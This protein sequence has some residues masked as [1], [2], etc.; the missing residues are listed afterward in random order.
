VSQAARNQPA[1]DRLARELQPAVLAV[2]RER[3]GNA[4]RRAIARAVRRLPLVALVVAC[5]TVVLSLRIAVPFLVP[6]LAALVAVTAYVL[7]VWTRSFQVPVSDADAALACD[8]AHQSRDRLSAAL[9]LSADPAL[10]ARPVHEAMAAAAIE[11][12]LAFLQRTD[13]GRVAASTERPAADWRSAAAAL[14]ALALFTWWLPL[15]GG[16]SG[17][18]QGTQSAAGG[19]AAQGEAGRR[20]VAAAAA[21]RTEAPPAS[22]KEVKS[23]PKAA[24]NERRGSPPPNQP[25]P[26]PAVPAAAGAGASG[27]DTAGDSAQSGSPKAAPT[28]SPGAGRPGGGQGSAAA[29]SAEPVPEQKKPQAN[30][31]KPRKRDAPKPSPEQ[32]SKNAESAGAPSGPSRGSGR[33]ASVANKRSDLERG[34]EREDDPDVE[35]EPVEDET[36]EQEQRGGLMPLK[37]QDQRP[38]ARELSISGD[39]PPDQGRGG[40]TPPKKS[41]GTA[42]LLLGLRLSDQVRGQPNPG[43]AKT[44]I[45]QIPPR[46]QAADPGLAHSAVPGRTG[47]PQSERPVQREDMG[48]LQAYHALLRERDSKPSPSPSP[49]TQHQ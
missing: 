11:D 40:P 46:R 30:P 5:V 14:L 29:S 7:V 23:E 24:A 1:H 3:T 39:G 45:E 16:T 34:M 31:P 27:S 22:G 28:G 49:G 26:A 37:R 19:A 47:T 35:D 20:D 41:R 43:T 44:S 36:N 4:A 12:G 38:A 21:R 33:M 18:R 42:S 13:P 32:D 25:E 15:P 9:Q 6:P 2:R 17:P 8:R 10:P 48:L